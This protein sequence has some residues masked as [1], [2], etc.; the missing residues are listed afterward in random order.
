MR[1]SFQV[2]QLLGLNCQ[3]LQAATHTHERLASPLSPPIVARPNVDWLDSWRCHEG[4]SK[5]LRPRPG[6]HPLAQE[7]YR[8]VFR[9]A[10]SST[11]CGEFPCGGG[12]A[13]LCPYPETL[14][15]L[16]AQDCSW[17]ALRAGSPHFAPGVPTCHNWG[18]GCFT[19]VR[20]VLP[21]VG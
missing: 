19:R 11:P 15:G 12:V 13:V 6:H 18:Q 8:L 17:T 2:R 3:L 10:F 5:E 9:P 1:L 16:R 14:E 20:A 4:A 21:S 7:H